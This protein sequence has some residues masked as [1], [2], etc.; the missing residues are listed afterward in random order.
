MRL[1]RELFQYREMIASLVRKDLKGRYKGSVL[2][3]LWTFINPLLQLLVYTMVFSVILKSGIEN[4]YL[5]LFVAL[6]PWI[7]FASSLTTGSHLILDQ[8]NMIKK[9][10]FPREVLPVAYT[11]SSFCNML[12]S[13]VIVFAVIA[14]MRIGVA[15]TVLPWLIPVMAIQYILV[16]GM[17]FITSSVTVYCRDLEHIMGVLSMAW[18]YLSP[19]VYGVQFIPQG[20]E[21]Y[22]MLNPMAPIILAYRDILYYKKMPDLGQLGLAFGLSVSVLLIGILVFE[23]LSKRFAEEL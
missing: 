23:K 4:Y 13:F 1:I 19:V 12:F 17:N 20:W 22:Y 16:L 15:W 3:F 6:V 5:H 10:Y 11:T 7:F 18:M 21:R 14:V 9:I 2:G 8:K